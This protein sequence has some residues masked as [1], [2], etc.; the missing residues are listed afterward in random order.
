MLA[1]NHCRLNPSMYMAGYLGLVEAQH[2][3]TSTSEVGLPPLGGCAILAAL[4]QSL[5]L[6]PADPF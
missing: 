5:I 6:R 1:G 4:S 2:N 3:P